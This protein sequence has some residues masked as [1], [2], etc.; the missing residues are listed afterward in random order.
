MDEEDERD[1]LQLLER[2]RQVVGR[3]RLAPRMAQLLDLA[4]E[5]PCHRG[6]A[7]AEL[8][9]GDGEH[10]LTRRAEVD[11]RRLERARPRAREEEHLGLGGGEPPSA[12]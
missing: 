1:R 11:D 9:C 2:A 7:L 12:A 8:A 5:R 10:T 6:P 4:T 3:G